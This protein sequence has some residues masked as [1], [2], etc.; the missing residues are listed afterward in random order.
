MLVST[1]SSIWAV[2]RVVSP[3]DRIET[4]MRQRDSEHSQRTTYAPQTE[5]KVRET[6]MPVK[7]S[8]KQ[9]KIGL[10]LT[11]SMRLSSRERAR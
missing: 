5:V 11:L 4:L 1:F 8:P 2:K 7:A 3:Y 6:H 10:L 9:T